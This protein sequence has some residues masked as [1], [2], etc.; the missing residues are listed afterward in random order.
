MTLGGIK[1]AKKAKNQTEFDLDALSMD[2]LT[3][4]AADVQKA[5][6]SVEKRRRQEAR[7]A[8]EKVARDYGM[9]LSDVLGNAPAARKAASGGAP[10][11]YRN[12]DDASQTW[13][14][15]GRQPGWYKAAIAGGADPSSMEI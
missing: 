9:S 15:R 8:M 5:I 14:G 4:L 11:K 10:A 7:Q 6:A 3:A 2:E 13:S 1:V 12:P